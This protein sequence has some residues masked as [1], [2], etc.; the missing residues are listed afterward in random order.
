MI[1]SSN[2]RLLKDIDIDK[3]YRN[4]FS[5]ASLTE[6]TNFFL[7]KTQNFY[8]DFS[9]MRKNEGR[10]IRIPNK[11]ESMWDVSY[12]MFQNSNYG[13]KWFYAFIT[14]MQYVSE[15]VTDVYFEIDMM[16]TWYF[17]MDIKDCYVEREHVSDDTIGKHLVDENLNTGEYIQRSTMNVPELQDL[18]I[19]IS[20]TSDNLG[21]ASTGDVY[22]GVYSGNAYY[23]YNGSS[24]VN[25]FI[26]DLNTLGKTDAINNI[27]LMPTYLIPSGNSAPI[28]ASGSPNPNSI[29][30]QLDKNNSDLDGYVPRNKKLLS[31]PYNF[32]LVKAG[33]DETA[34]FRPEYF[35]DPNIMEFFIT[36][37]LGPSPTVFLIP[38]NY[39]GNPENFEELMTL[40]DYP[41][42]DWTSDIYKIWKAQNAVSS[43][44]AIA[45]SALS[46]ISGMATGNAIGM[47]S[48]AISMA[49]SIG[50]FYEK[51]VIPNADHG[52]A[53]GGGNVAIGNQNFN[54]YYKTIRAEFAQ[55]IDNYFDRY[56]YKVNQ[57]K[58]PN[59]RTRLNWN[60]LKTHECNISGNIPNNDLS[61]IH[62]IF[63][64]GI[65]FWHNDAVGQ[66]TGRDNSPI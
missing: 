7:G 49:Q 40:K 35:S 6:Q 53:G 15:N 43:K 56:G 29:D 21:N 52:H 37:D 12:L 23:A 31:Y 5:W 63:N 38:K 50:Q 44:V 30:K 51:S 57:L 48:G 9:Y 32:L 2:V 1:P 46:L 4:T 17:D 62:S 27:F 28:V 42:C 39:K 66:Y 64:Q 10:P 8:T 59:F 19:V 54:F 13:N 25:T 41:I 61:K 47:A 3:D 22:A 18:S 60:Y 24:G 34:I 26:D 16:Q 14:D 55:I 65:T 20:S 33:T 11:I 58:V 45:G 36:S